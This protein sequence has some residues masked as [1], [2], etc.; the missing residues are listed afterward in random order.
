[1]KKKI[2]G[3][4]V[5]MLL[6]ITAIPAVESL[7]DR[8]ITPI[9]PSSIAKPCALDT[10]NDIQ[11]RPTS[12]GAANDTFG[13]PVS[14]S[15]GTALIGTYG[16]DGKGPAY[17]FT[18]EAGNKPPNIPSIQGETNGKVG[19]PYNYTFV[20]TDPDGDDVYYCINWSDGTSNAWIGPF[21]SGAEE[22]APH[23]WSQKGTY[24]IKV[25]AKDV[26]G[27]ETLYSDWGTL[28]VTMP[29]SYNIPLS[30]FWVRLLERFPNTFPILRHLLGY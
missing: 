5:C 11:K 18:K 23:T 15:G 2:L 16:D 30:Q 7:N 19:K 4:F 29:C 26:R 27:D 21:A 20:T 17:V 6:I 14:L 10:W 8:T 12:D 13:Y 25:K 3:M 22:T 1:M 28:S 24:I 9:V